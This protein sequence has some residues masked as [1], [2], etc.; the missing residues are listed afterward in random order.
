M[1][2]VLAVTVFIG[3]GYISDFT[4]ATM[5]F[6]EKPLALSVNVDIVYAPV[7]IYAMAN[8]IECFPWKRMLT[9]LKSIGKYS[10][11]M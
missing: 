8:L 7:F 1:W 5:T 11:H 2:L 9:P 3:R 6:S 10:L 4:I